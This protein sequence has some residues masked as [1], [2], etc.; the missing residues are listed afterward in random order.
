MLLRGLSSLLVEMMASISIEMACQTS[1]NFT[2]LTHRR[3]HLRISAIAAMVMNIRPPSARQ[4][5]QLQL[6]QPS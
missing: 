6:F 3:D 1:L 5:N 4:T 2:V